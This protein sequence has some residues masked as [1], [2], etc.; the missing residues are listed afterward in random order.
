MKTLS[1]PAPYRI[2]TQ[3]GSLFNH[4][5]S[6]SAP[7]LPKVGMGCTV[8][9]WSDRHAATITEVSKNGKRV[10]IVEDIATRVDGNGMSDAQEYSYS[11]GAGA[12]T[13]YTL[14]KNGAFVREGDTLK[15]TRI[16]I[17]AHNTYHDFSF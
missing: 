6:G 11:P 14:R 8:L 4:L 5:M 12:P 10:G 3:T 16:A 17:G 1:A 2:G 13:Y 15:G 9:M 7:L